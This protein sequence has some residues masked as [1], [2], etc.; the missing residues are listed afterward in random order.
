MNQNKRLHWIV[1]SGRKINPEKKSSKLKKKNI[2]RQ[3]WTDNR[4]EFNSTT[5]LEELAMNWQFLNKIWRPDTYIINGKNSYLHK[6]TVP[7]RFIRISPSGRISYSQRLTLIARKVLMCF[8]QDDL[9]CDQNFSKDIKK[10]GLFFHKSGSYL[11]LDELKIAKTEQT[12]KFITETNGM[13][14][15]VNW[16]RWCRHKWMCIQKTYYNKKKK[17]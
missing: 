4:L 10:L 13:Q 16:E 7:N 11:V 14:C 1:I 15:F 5:S 2:F 3:Y 8:F 12:P 6:M 9:H 17:K